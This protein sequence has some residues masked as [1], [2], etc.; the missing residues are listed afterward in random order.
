MICAQDVTQQGLGWILSKVVENSLDLFC[1]I[2]H[3]WSDL[4]CFVF[5][6]RR[7]C[8]CLVNSIPQHHI[9]KVSLNQLSYLNLLF[10]L[11]VSALFLNRSFYMNL[12]TLCF[13]THAHIMESQYDKLECLTINHQP[14]SSLYLTRHQEKGLKKRKNWNL[15]HNEQ[16]QQ[17]KRFELQGPSQE[18]KTRTPSTLSI[19]S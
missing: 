2:L 3:V 9:A 6:P 12:D 13:I 16:E 8:I 19:A 1:F 11:E 17:E 15:D 10:I 4:F 5:F 18:A 7:H 14:L